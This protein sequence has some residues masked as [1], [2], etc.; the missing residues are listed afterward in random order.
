MTCSRSFFRENFIPYLD[1]DLVASRSS[2][3]PS[4]ASPTLPAAFFVPFTVA[5][6]T[7]SALSGDCR[8]LFD[9]LNGL[10][11]HVLGLVRGDLTGVHSALGG[12]FRALA[13]AF[14]HV[15]SASDNL[16]VL[17]ILFRLS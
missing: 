8:A 15:L 12:V 2:F 14:A 9:A 10:L 4:S 13:D 11:S 3:F 5:S 17:Q 16:A 1:L 6:P 7:S